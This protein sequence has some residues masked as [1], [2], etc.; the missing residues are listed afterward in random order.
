[1]K[2]VDRLKSVIQ[3]KDANVDKLLNGNQNQEGHNLTLREIIKEKD[4]Q[5]EAMMTKM[6][7]MK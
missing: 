4:L 1:M 3:E 7:L 6:D 2:E 5:I